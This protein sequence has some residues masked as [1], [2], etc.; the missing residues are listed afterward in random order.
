M[1]RRNRPPAF[2]M[3]VM[4]VVGITLFHS[5]LLHTATCVAWHAVGPVV[6]YYWV[7]NCSVQPATDFLFTPHTYWEAFSLYLVAIVRHSYHPVL[8][9]YRIFPILPA[10]VVC[11]VTLGPTYMVYNSRAPCTPSS[12]TCM[13]QTVHLPTTTYTRS[14]HTRLLLF[15]LGLLPLIYSFFLLPI[16]SSVLP[17]IPGGDT[18]WMVACILTVRLCLGD[19]QPAPCSPQQAHQSIMSSGYTR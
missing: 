13:S 15:C 16:C 11:G 5:A 18:T 1:D 3:P 19:S 17:M 14:I 2:L 10:V 9:G 6:L 7:T 8:G 12:T 4:T